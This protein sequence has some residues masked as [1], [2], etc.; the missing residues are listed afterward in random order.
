MRRVGVGDLGDVAEASGLEM[1]Q[2]WRQKSP[3]RISAIRGGIPVRSQPSLDECA[4]QPRPHRALVVNR[5][6]AC[7]IPLIP[8]AVAR[9]GWL[10]RP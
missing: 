2:H 8:S 3:A 7:R 5:V 1:I 6:A 9:V 10:E 4:D